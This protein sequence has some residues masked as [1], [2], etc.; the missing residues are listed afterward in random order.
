MHKYY[1]G[2]SSGKREWIPEFTPE[3]MA[4]VEFGSFLLW[5]ATATPKEL[6]EWYKL[7][8]QAKEDKTDD[9]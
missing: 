1:F 7:N 8:T 6:E 9:K 4:D 2:H 3:E 5:L